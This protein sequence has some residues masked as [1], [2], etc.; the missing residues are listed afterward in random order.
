[1]AGYGCAGCTRDTSTTSPATTGGSSTTATASVSGLTE[2]TTRKPCRRFTQEVARARYGAGLQ[3]LVTQTT[4]F[5]RARTRLANALL[6]LGTD[7]AERARLANYARN[8]E[9]N[10]SYL[11]Q[12]RTA[13]QANNVTLAYAALETWKQRLAAETRLVEQLGL[14]NCPQ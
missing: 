11:R 4:T 9:A 2:R 14:R 5:E 1:M 10:N 7:N 8:L 6:E 13:A 12:A 3:Q